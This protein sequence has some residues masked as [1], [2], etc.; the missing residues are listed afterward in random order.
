[1]DKVY[2]IQDANRE[3]LTDGIEKLNR[4]ACRLGLPPIVLTIGKAWTR[5]TYSNGETARADEPRPVG[6]F[7]LTYTDSLVAEARL[8]GEP[9]RLNGWEFI[10]TLQH[11]DGGTILRTVPT[12]D[13]PA[14][15]LDAYR[16]ASPECTHCETNRRR[17]DT[18]VVRHED[19][20][21]AQVGRN[22]LQSFIG[23]DPEK[24]A[25]LAEFL[26]AADDMG[27]EAEFGEGGGGRAIIRLPLTSF[28]AATLAAIRCY[29]W[30]SRSKA[31]ETDGRATA[32]DAWGHLTS[33]GGDKD[34][35]KELRD[36]DGPD[37]EALLAEASAKLD[38][39]GA[40]LSDYEHNL[41]VAL[42]SGL[43]TK[44]TAGIVA[45]VVGFVTRAREAAIEASANPS[46]WM[47]VEGEKLTTTATVL[48]LRT[49]EGEY[50]PSTFVNLR[51]AEG[52]RLVWKASGGS[53][54][55]V[56]P[57]TLDREP[58]TVD[59]GAGFRQF[60]VRV[61]DVV[62]LTG[63]VKRHDTSRK[64]SQRET[65]MTRCALVAPEAKPLIE[66]WTAAEKVRK[67]AERKA[68]AKAKREADKAAKA[69]A[70]KAPAEPPA[71]EVKA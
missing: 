29:G 24:L 66:A 8:V 56:A 35:R 2:T 51:T 58:L 34:I 44:R 23:G 42:L 71:T 47:G 18:F 6:C 64:T 12:A 5:R 16:E 26:A 21:V 55:F 36:A 11:E 32:D 38:A 63:T 30:L 60:E 57:A 15:T 27:T 19:G 40:K 69:E 41:R 53:V 4:R 59:V 22:C 43:V 65:W 39:E 10:A 37:A 33:P 17:G 70:A 1:M 45:S 62:E 46:E 54:D 67:A 25:K 50:G 68:A 52:N 13:V 20:R 14:G 7:G 9:V 49:V 31:R 48:S 28:V 3:T 61:G